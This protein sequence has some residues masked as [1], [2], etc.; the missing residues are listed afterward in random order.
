MGARALI[1]VV[2][3]DPLIRD[4]VVKQL[5]RQGYRTAA[6]AD[7]KEMREQ[8]D[9]SSPDLVI[10]DLR[11]PDKDGLEVARELRAE[12]DVGIIMLTGL[13]DTVDKIVGL[14][15]GADDYVTKPFEERE[16]LARVGTVLRRTTRARE[17]APAKGQPVVEFAGWRLDLIGHELR[18]PEGKQVHLTNHEFQLLSA[19]AEQPNRV[20]SRDQILDI[21]GQR[22][23]SPYDRSVDVLVGKLRRKIEKTPKNPDFIKTIRGVG[24]KFTVLVSAPPS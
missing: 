23:W 2:D 24:Y 22:E 17:L 12:S 13:G 9:I 7:Y 4:L 1:L 3:D 18:S 16:L 20:L 15:I 8:M 11:L 14:E 10:L 6:A 21:V 19:F 5:S